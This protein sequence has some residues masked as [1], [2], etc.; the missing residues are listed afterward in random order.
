MSNEEYWIV[1]ERGEEFRRKR[2][3]FVFPTRKPPHDSL[4]FGWPD[5]ILMEALDEKQKRGRLIPTSNASPN[6]KLVG[7]LA[8]P[9]P[10]ME[11]T[12]SYDSYMHFKKMFTDECKTKDIP[13]W[14]KE[15]FRGGQI[16][17]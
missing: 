9:L 10:P 2:I 6:K 13:N 12:P 3:L 8:A 14:R 1:H 17:E 15:Y 16:N 11:G 4:C 7:Y 5:L